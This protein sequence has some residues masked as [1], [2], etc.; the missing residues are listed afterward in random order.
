MGGN[1]FLFSPNERQFFLRRREGNVKKGGA[2]FLGNFGLFWDDYP[3]GD[4]GNSNV[5]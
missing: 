2:S 4:G 3:W 5:F 1:A